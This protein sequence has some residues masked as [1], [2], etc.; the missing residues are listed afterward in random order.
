MKFTASTLRPMLGMLLFLALASCQ[1]AFAQVPTQEP[2]VGQAVFCDSPDYVEH[3][4]KGSGDDAAVA[5]AVTE[6]NAAHPKPVCVN[7]EAIFFRAPGEVRRVTAGD[8][9]EY[10]I[11]E[12]L[13]IGIVVQ[14][15]PIPIPPS[16]MYAGVDEE[17]TPEQRDARC[18]GPARYEAMSEGA[19]C[20]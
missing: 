18:E 15:R 20:A 13:V 1:P 5:R 3:I 6:I 12:L 16:R 7:A 11:V 8:G 4:F 17:D 19:S 10:V 2:Q 9:N 14:G